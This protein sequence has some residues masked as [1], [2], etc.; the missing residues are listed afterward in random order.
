MTWIGLI[1]MLVTGIALFL[2]EALKC[3][4]I[5]AF[6]YKMLFLFLGIL[7]YVTIHRSITKRADDKI[8]PIWGRV[9]A[10]VSLCLW[11]GVAL[12]GRAIG[13]V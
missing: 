6:P 7:V 12:A 8:G 4:V 13:F 11:F 9:V 1:T 2:S 5:A 10:V 3:Y